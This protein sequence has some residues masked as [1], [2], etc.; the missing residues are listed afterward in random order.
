MS[1]IR[2]DRND[3]P[4]TLYAGGDH[5]YGALQSQHQLE[6]DRLREKL[7]ELER[8]TQQQR[9]LESEISE[10]ARITEAFDTRL[11]VHSPPLLFNF[12]SLLSSSPFFPLFWSFSIYF[13]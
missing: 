1:E 12:S 11:Q 9:E 7:R 8:I 5:L 13:L 10:M 6:H 4:S 2:S 3:I